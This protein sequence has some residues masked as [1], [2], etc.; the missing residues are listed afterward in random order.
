MSVGNLT[1]VITVDKLTRGS[2]FKFQLPPI[3][4]LREPVQKI[5][6]HLQVNEAEG[7]SC[8][9]RAEN[10]HVRHNLAFYKPQLIGQL[11]CELNQ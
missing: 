10:V 7:L 4:I 2:V 1:V 9:A 6:I 3:P 11:H 5:V 8:V